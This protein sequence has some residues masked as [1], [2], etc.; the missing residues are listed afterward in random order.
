M[1]LNTGNR[2]VSKDR[3]LLSRSIEST[4]E[5]NQI[6]TVIIYKGKLITEL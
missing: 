5:V 1:V 2:T 3:F 6:I 4:G